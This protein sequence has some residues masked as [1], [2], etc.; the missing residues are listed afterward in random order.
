MHYGNCTTEKKW[1]SKFIQIY[2]LSKL[3]HEEKENLNR[4]P[5]QKEIEK[6]I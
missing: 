4:S 2:T 6:V 3:T 1:N 5:T